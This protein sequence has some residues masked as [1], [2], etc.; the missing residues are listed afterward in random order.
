MTVRINDIV[1]EDIIKL[2]FT[3][4]YIIV[5]DKSGMHKIDTCDFENGVMKEPFEMIEF[6]S[7]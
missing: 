2:D 4:R 7:K 1:Y 3:D 5:V 6:I